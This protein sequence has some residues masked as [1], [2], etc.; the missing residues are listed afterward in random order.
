MIA[1][2][3]REDFHPA[4]VAMFEYPRGRPDIGK[5][6]ALAGRHDHQ[7]E[8]FRALL[9]D[10]AGKRCGDIHLG[11]AGGD[12]P[13]GL[14]DGTVGNAGEFSQDDDLFRGLDLPHP[15]QQRLCG[16][17]LRARQQ[18]AEVGEIGSRQI[19]QLDADARVA[20]AV[21]RQQVGQHR[22]GV[23][24]KFAPHRD[25]DL[26]WLAL[27]PTLARIVLASISTTASAAVPSA[28]TTTKA[29]RQRISGWVGTTKPVT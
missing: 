16:R 28:V 29:C 23:E 6:A 11:R 2:D 25:L 20:E 14:R 4:D 17:E 5:H 19:I 3:D 18:P 9:V 12:R 1:L 7:L 21:A 22:H 10:P 27:A 15:R 24:R 8:I 26:S 13:V